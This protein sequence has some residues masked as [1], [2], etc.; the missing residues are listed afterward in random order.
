MNFNAD[1]LGDKIEISSNTIGQNCTNDSR[2]VGIEF[3]QVS[4]GTNTLITKNV[5]SNL[6]G[7]II[8]HGGTKPV[9]RDNEFEQ[10]S[11]IANTYGT[12][13][14]LKGDISTVVSPTVT[15]NSISQNSTIGSYKPINVANVSYAYIHDNR[16]ALGAA[17][18]YDYITVTGA[19]GQTIFGINR[20]SYNT[21]VSETLDTSCAVAS[22]GPSGKQET[23][24]AWK[25]PGSTS[26][27]ATITTQAAAG[28][29]TL[30]LPIS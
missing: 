18:T 7:M 29:P 25:I 24:Y 4:G 22:L 20:C 14:D 9:I 3:S 8:V 28:T 6:N 12:L 30:S 5:I 13:I 26:G 17:V 2:C 19:A 15:G 21:A 1:F 23:P 11:G 10:T 16:I 27:L